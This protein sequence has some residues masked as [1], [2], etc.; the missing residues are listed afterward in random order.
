M[1][2]TFVNKSQVTRATVKHGDVVQFRPARVQV[3]L[4][5]LFE[6]VITGAAARETQDIPVEGLLLGGRST[7]K[8]R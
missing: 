5:N 8:L 4:Q 6:A 1:N 2:G 3:V 7:S